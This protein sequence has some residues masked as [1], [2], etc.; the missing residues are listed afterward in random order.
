WE[1]REIEERLQWDWD[2]SWSQGQT[3]R[4]PVDTPEELV[5]YLPELGGCQ[6]RRDGR[7]TVT[8]IYLFGLHLRR[9]GGVKRK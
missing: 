3:I 8:D 9:K 2:Q 4:P 7:I 6:Q 1:R 5:D